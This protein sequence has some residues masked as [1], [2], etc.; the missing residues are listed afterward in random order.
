MQT[1]DGD[2]V[3]EYNGRM[4]MPADGYFFDGNWLNL[5]D[6]PPDEVIALT[7]KEAE[8]IYKETDYYTI[9]RGFNAFFH[10]G[11]VDWQCRMLTDPDEILRGQRELP[12]RLIERVDKVIK[13]MGNYIQAITVGGDLGLQ[14]GPAINPD[15]YKELCAPFLGK[16]CEFIHNNSDLKILCT[17]VVPLDRL[18]PRW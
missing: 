17:A 4:K 9:Y 7:A 18:F 10:E 6:K 2:W 16:F 5:E 11:N 8:R 13:C 3:V 12:D 15:V 14:N 1:K